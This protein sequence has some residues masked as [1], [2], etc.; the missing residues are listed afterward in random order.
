VSSSEKV[1]VAIL[2]SGNIGTDLMIKILETSASLELVSVAGIDPQSDGL[3]KAR[4][5]GIEATAEGIDGLLRLPSTSSVSIVFDATSAQ[6]HKEHDAK[7]R[8]LGKRVIDLTP[9]AIGP[10]SVPVVNFDEHLDALNVNMVSCG[11]QATV[12]IVAAVS[13]VAKVHYAEIVASIASRS[14]G[15][16]TRA[17]IDEFTATTARALETVG[18]ATRGKAIIILNPAEPPLIM[19]DTV[20]ILSNMAETSELERSI[21]A[22]I[23]EVQKY[24]PGYRLKQA[25]QFERIGGNGKLNIPGLGEFEGIKTS[26]FLEVEGA[27]H[28]LP[29]YAGNLDIM[30]S[31]AVATAEKI[32]ARLRGES[33]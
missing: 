6:A 2:G 30:T 19:R 3:A 11:G 31:A 10:Y 7:L 28:Y 14:A 25:I 18:G 33:P 17:N 20:Y 23:R 8:A 24:V 13:R 12:P 15:P 5:L 1:S 21:E 4:E 9:A 32:A 16:G 26:I 27:A 22:M 29:A